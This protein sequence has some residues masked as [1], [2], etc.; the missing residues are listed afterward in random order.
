MKKPAT[1]KSPEPPRWADQFLAWFCAPHLLEELQGDLHEEFYYQVDRIGEQRA[2]RRYIR[3]VLGFI[4]PFAIKR[5]SNSYPAAANFST[6]LLQ[7]DMLKHYFTIGWRHLWRNKGYTAIN[8]VGL[9]V[10]FCICVF[11][12]LTAYL[13]L[14]YD[15]FHQ[16][17][18]QIFQAYLFANDPAKATRS[19]A[20]PLPLTPTLKAEYAEVEA[21]TRVLRNSKSLV[22]YQDKHFDQDVVLTDADFLKIFTFPLLHGNPETALVDLNSILLSQRLAQILFGNGDPIGKVVQHTS[23]GKKKAFIVTGVLADAPTNSTIRYDA[24]IRIENMP[25]Y[26]ADQNN[27]DAFS[28]Q[29]YIKLKPQVNLKT[30]ERRLK[31]FAPKY[32]QQSLVDLKKKG[33]RPDAQ[34]DILALRV[35]QLS[36]IHFDREISNGPPIAIVYALLGI[37]FF[38]LLIA[39]FN[40]INLSIARAFTRAKE[41]GVRKYLGALK[42]QLFVQIWGESGITCF[43]GLALGALLAYVLLPEF[44]AVFDS[45]LQLIHLLQPG[46]IAFL[47]GVFGI[48]T[49]IAGGYPA[50]LMSRFNAVAV[51]KGK[52]SLKRPG[53]LRNSLLVTQFA[54]SCLLTCCTLVALQQVD[55]LRQKPLG[56]E[57]EQLISIPVGNQVNGRQVLQRLR[58]KL[59]TDPAVL[60]VTGAGVNLGKGKDRS[61]SRTT[62]NFDYQGR[63][64]SANWLLIDYDYLKILKIPVIT[65]REFDPAYPSDS[66]DRLIITA[67]LAQAMGEKQALGTFLH[68]AGRRQQVIGVIPDFHLYSVA[69]EQK[70]IILHLSAAEPINYIFVRVAPQSLTGAM[71]K[72]KK[73]WREVAPGSEFLGS[74]LDEN[75]NAWYQDEEMM[76][77]IFSMASVIAIL[78]SCSGLFAVALLVMEQRTKEIGIRKVLGASFTDIL[79]ILSKDFV[80]LVLVALVIA[81][82]LAWF[83]MQ[84]WL[85]SYS[86]RIQIN[87]WLFAIV[88]IMAIALTLVMIGFQ[89]LK[90]AVRNPVKSLR[91]E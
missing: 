1:P 48:I 47:L 43:I 72:M 25:G 88:A 37:G 75:V 83:G 3:E 58:N 18:E 63:D 91:T 32:L 14:T 6:F 57:K 70:P 74:F 16:H 15:S 53:F 5:K 78:L 80:K 31:P 30:F 49:V 76:A 68:V 60:A 46:F 2:R 41:M 20:M 71:H 23:G 28:H 89:S 67:S 40:F 24:L 33:A 51:L 4:R 69:E 50:W 61:T 65:G 81:I 9:A 26:R 77:R 39:C 19:G 22:S 90:A 17:K 36:K 55:Y 27:W 29:A 42:T 11:L 59:T 54:L 85:N 82:P 7:P 66:V 38:I 64:L 10:A 44:N 73:L 86:Y 87:G 45:R 79:F 34:G 62:L 56:F 84:Q 21:A 52:I 8:V 13:Q 35:Q 12:F